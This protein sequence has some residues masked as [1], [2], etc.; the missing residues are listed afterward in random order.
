MAQGNIPRRIYHHTRCLRIKCNSS[1]LPFLLHIQ[2][3]P[4]IVISHICPNMFCQVGRECSGSVSRMERSC[5]TGRKTVIPQDNRDTPGIWIYFL[6]LQS[7]GFGLSAYTGSLHQ[8]HKPVW[9]KKET[10]CSQNQFLQYKELVQHTLLYYHP[11]IRSEIEEMNKSSCL[12][13]DVSLDHSHIS[14]D[15]GKIDRNVSMIFFD[16]F[17]KRYPRWRKVVHK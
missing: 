8:L 9:G 1:S 16:I 17:T 15:K 14:K 13:G 3:T 12:I 4:R 7:S 6:R 2:C 10:E 5:R 11:W